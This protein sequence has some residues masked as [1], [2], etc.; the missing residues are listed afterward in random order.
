MTSITWA[1]PRCVQELATILKP[2]NRIQG[3]C[4]MILLLLTGCGGDINPADLCKVVHS[5]HW[6]RVQAA[7]QG[8]DPNH[9]ACSTAALQ[10]QTAANQH[11]QHTSHSCSVRLQIPGHI[12]VLVKESVSRHIDC[13]AGCKGTHFILVS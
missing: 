2:Q 11:P 13:D 4:E 7:G 12:L 3:H 8:A 9:G 1:G 5:L 10:Q 6:A